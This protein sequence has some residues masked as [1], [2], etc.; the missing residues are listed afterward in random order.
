MCVH[1]SICVFMIVYRKMFNHS[2]TQING[3]SLLQNKCCCCCT[4]FFSALKLI[5][6]AIATSYDLIQHKQYTSS[7]VRVSAFVYRLSR[8]FDLTH[9]YDLHANSKMKISLTASINIYYSYRFNKL[10]LFVY[11]I[12]I[13]FI[14]IMM[15]RAL[16]VAFKANNAI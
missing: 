15:M 14:R 8:A 12:S 4:R 3:V 13:H 10:N 5:H 7:Y 1:T 11:S 16:S 2:L 9:K 6:V